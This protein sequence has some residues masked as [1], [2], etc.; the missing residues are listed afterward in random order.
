MHITEGKYEH[1]VWAS[2]WKIASIRQLESEKELA[3]RRRNG[4]EN[5]SMRDT[6]ILTYRDGNHTMPA[7][8][9]KSSTKS[10]TIQHNTE[11]NHDA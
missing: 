10:S 7:S 1:L 9:L 11:Q 5:Q 2:E 4:K 8:L 6:Y 3:T